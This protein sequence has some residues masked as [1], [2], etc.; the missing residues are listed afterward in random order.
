LKL[1]FDPDYNNGKLKAAELLNGFANYG[2]EQIF[3][4]IDS[5]SPLVAVEEIHSYFEEMSDTMLD[6]ILKTITLDELKI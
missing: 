6:D 2:I 4:K 5:V 3:S 1:A